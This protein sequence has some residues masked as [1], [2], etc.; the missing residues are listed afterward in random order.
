[1]AMDLVKVSFI[2][3]MNVHIKKGKNMIDVN[4]MK[5]NENSGIVV[6][7]KAHGGKTN[8]LIELANKED[9]PLFF[10][11]EE[12]KES[13][14]SKGLKTSAIIGLSIHDFNDVNELIRFINYKNPNKKVF[15]DGVQM[16]VKDR[17]T[18]KDLENIPDYVTI[19]IQTKLRK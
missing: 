3:A 6:S 11:V 7:S 16:M 4:V 8:Y 17:I 5:Y 13:L 9:E 15:I 12:T 14:I 1:M 10:H 2:V 19:T 18:K